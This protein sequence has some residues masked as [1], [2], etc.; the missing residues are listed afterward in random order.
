MNK[1]EKLGSLKEGIQLLVGGN[2]LLTVGQELASQFKPG[3]HLAIVEKTNEVLH[4]PQTE[5]V[6][7]EQAVTTTLSAF[8]QMGVVTDAQIDKF[9]EG[10]A[11]RLDDDSI[12]KKIAQANQADVD[13]AKARG[14]STT[15]LIA[16]DKMRADMI[17]GLRGW[18]KASSVRGKVLETIHH[19]TWKAEL[20]GAELGVVAFVFEGR[21]N[22]VADAT[23]V[24]RGGNTVVFRIGR[25]ALG[26]A[27]AIIELAT[28]PALKEAGLPAG[29]VTVVDSASH[30]AGWALFGDQRLALAVARGSGAAVDTLGSLAQSA[31]VPV[32]LHGTGGAWL[33]AGASASPKNLTATV[34]D[35]LDR[36]VCN[37][38]N[39]CCIPLA[40]ASLLVPAFLEGMRLAA[41]IRKTEFKLH[42]AE[43]S[44]DF[45]PTELFSK[46]VLVARAEG[47][48]QEAQ[49]QMIASDRLG[50]EWEWEDSPEV[51][52]KIVEDVAEAVRLFNEQSPQF[53]ASLLS[54]DPGEQ[55]SF[56][57]SVNAPFVGDGF[58][59]WVDGQY[60]LKRPELG[61]SNWE[62]GRLFG[63][64]GVLSGDSVFTVRTR[65]TG[66][67]T[68]RPR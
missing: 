16:T 27:K 29:A 56:W 55:E 26:S 50:H 57:S 48:V 23:G 14:R 35:S 32:S 52:L 51:T 40:Q 62:N 41:Q 67:K 1:V 38:V 59:R 3:D 21:P 66:T 42:V 22:V 15:R 19:G 60:A 44:E 25:D 28:E 54:E 45:V 18:S 2:R 30:A 39:T 43:G 36:K 63:R 11:S 7:A 34:R 65:V 47:Q 5:K 37:T 4:I 46:Q 13:Q 31:G 49:A 53:V 8:A 58:T 61:L 68:G 20:I 33:I 64:G 17:E 12:W 24:L 10:F 6:V 9:F